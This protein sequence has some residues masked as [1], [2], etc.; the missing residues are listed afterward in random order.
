[1]YSLIKEPSGHEQK[2]GFYDVP[3]EIVLRLQ[4]VCGG[5]I[6]S[7]ETAFGGFSASASFVI[8]LSGG[9]KFFIKGTHPLDTSHGAENLRQEI[10]AYETLP[11]LG[12]ISP[13]YIGVVSDGTGD[14]G[15]MLGAWEYVEH[16][17]DLVSLDAVVDVLRNWPDGT[18]AKAAL[19][20]AASH[21]FI[22]RLFDDERKWLRIRAN[23]DVRK[24]FLSL[25]A[26]PKA[27]GWLEKNISALCGLQEKGAGLLK[28]EGIIHG[29]LRLDNMLFTGEGVRV[30]DWP[31]ICLGP[32][33]FDIA[34]LYA[35]LEAFGLC[36]FDKALEA[37]DGG[38]KHE[39]VPVMLGCLSGYFADQAYRDTPLSM[40]R[41]RWMQRSMLLA[42]LN[43]LSR[44]GIIESPPHMHGEMQP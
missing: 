40:P 26:D 17:S 4:E 8:T 1:M 3:P 21:V 7:A 10:M 38:V 18:A 30:I 43:Q 5:K 33:V 42:Q 19:V 32:R 20:P 12:G 36:P 14:D 27:A 24:K 9:K 29:D 11:A 25:F 35:S 23:E 28:P 22:G 2:P 6:A 39:D 16:R 31:N 41:L 34:F 37:F 44:M 15:W 13:K